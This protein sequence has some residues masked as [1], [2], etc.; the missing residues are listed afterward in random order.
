MKRVLLSMFV[1]LCHIVV[2]AE[3][4]ALLVTL[5]DGTTAGY[6]LSEKPIVTFGESTLQ[7]KSSEASTEY[8]RA[9]VKHF[10]FVDA[11]VLG[12]APLSKGSTVFEFKN[13]TVRMDGAP[14]IIYTV[15]GEL[16]KK[17]IGTVSIEDQPTGVYIIKMNNQSIKV[18]KR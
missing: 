1:L 9:D 7:I 13:N 17:G 4:S 3:G 14:I 11:E 2:F 16:V 6:L 8:N 10:T 18:V 5:S 12:I 15:N